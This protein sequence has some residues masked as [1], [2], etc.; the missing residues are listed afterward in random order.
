V[1]VRVVV[2]DDHP[3][4][5][6]GLR[7]VLATG[8]QVVVA[9]EA[10]TGEEAVELLASTAADVVLMDLNMPGMGGVEAIRRIAPTTAVVVLTM[11]DD[12]A[13]LTAA[14]RAG[15]CGY[16]VKGAA[17]EAVLSA[18][19][20]AA[21]GESVF[22]AVVADR[23][24]AQLALGGEP[25]FPELTPRERDVLRLL[26]KGLTNAAIAERL[27]LSQKSVRNV[28]SSVLSKLGSADRHDAADRA[29]RAGL[30]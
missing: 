11:S 21:R 12:D 18:V 14:M 17:P 4:F 15:A 22:G 19:Q 1:S 8:D 24:R 16:L 2:V 29:R 13:A 6:E 23:V 30:V 27:V 10:T 26:G 25:A 28:V 7:A 3:V 20:A 5:R 9:G